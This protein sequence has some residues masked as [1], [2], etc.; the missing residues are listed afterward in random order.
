MQTVCVY[1]GSNAGAKPIYT[2]RAIA[3]GT[4]TGEGRPDAWSTAA[5]TSA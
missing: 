2:E 5:A 1:C 3:L 4:R